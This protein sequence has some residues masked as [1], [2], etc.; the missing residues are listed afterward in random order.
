MTNL[1]SELR[2]SRDESFL[3]APIKWP[4]AI[5]PVKRHLRDNTVEYGVVAFFKTTAVFV[6]DVNEVSKLPI[7]DI[8]KKLATAKTHE[9]PTVREL[10]NNWTIGK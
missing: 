7:N 5:V 3:Q 10:V 1:G 2:K 9:Y 8:Y 4:R 6:T